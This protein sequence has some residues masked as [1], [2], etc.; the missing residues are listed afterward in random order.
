MEYVESIMNDVKWLGFQWKE[1]VHYA[2]D[3]FPQLYE[4]A[5]RLIRMG[6]AY[7]DDQTGQEIHDTRGDLKTPGTDSPWRNRTAEENLKLFADMKAGVYPDGSKV[8]RAKLIW[9]HP[10]SLCGI[11]CCTGL[12]MHLTS[13]QAVH[14]AFIP[15]M[16]LHI[17]C[18]MLLR[19]LPIP[20]AH[21][22]LKSGGLF[23]IGVFRLL[24]DRKTAPDRIRPFE[25]DNHD[26]QQEKIE[27]DGG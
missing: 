16:I 15:C 17:P 4:F 24:T 5:C 9:H 19:V 12:S 23:I 7:V 1:P 14:G 25:C 20:Y 22:N 6:L 10:I 21:L 3:Y 2:S 27:E 26:H 8:L 18:Q 13:G 11:L